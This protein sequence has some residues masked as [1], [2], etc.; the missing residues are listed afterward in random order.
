[1]PHYVAIERITT[2]RGGRRVTIQPGQ[3]F[4]FSD[5]EVESL[6]RSDTPAIRQPVRENVPAAAA[7]EPA[8]SPTTGRRG[9]RG[10]QDD[11]EDNL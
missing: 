5:E 4:D 1:M 10:R 11:G 8:P 3:A 9:R 6:L 2:S 7:P